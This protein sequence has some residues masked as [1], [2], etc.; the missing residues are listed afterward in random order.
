MG[1]RQ[2][3]K[4]PSVRPDSIEHKGDFEV[5]LFTT[6]VYEKGAEIMRM[7]QEN[8]WTGRWSLF[9]ITQQELLFWSD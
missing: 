3:S 6:T 8:D 9:Q 1:S 5:S 4:G 7:I 2:R